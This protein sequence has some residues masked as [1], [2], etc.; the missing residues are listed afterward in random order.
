MILRDLNSYLILKII[1]YNT[2]ERE[3]RDVLS[4]YQ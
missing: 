3:I 4:Y 1:E 2:I